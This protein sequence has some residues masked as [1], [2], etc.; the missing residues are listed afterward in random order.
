MQKGNAN[1]HIAQ[2]FKVSNPIH[3]NVLRRKSKQETNFLSVDFYN[4]GAVFRQLNV[5]QPSYWL[6]CVQ[7][8][9]FMN[10]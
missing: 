6:L 8:R 5:A 7:F 4:F 3:C 1:V 9:L 10:D 2:L